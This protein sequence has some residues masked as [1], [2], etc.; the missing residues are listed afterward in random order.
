MHR[1]VCRGFLIATLVL[2]VSQTVALAQIVTPS[3]QGPELPWTWSLQSYKTLRTIGVGDDALT[4]EIADTSDLQ[5]RG[6]SY[7]DGLE[8]GTGMLFVYPDSRSHTFWMKGMRFCLDIIWIDRGEITGAAENVCPEPGVADVALARYPSTG[9]AQF[10]LEVPAGWLDDHGYGAGT[11]VDLSTV[12][13][14]SGL[15]GR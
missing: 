10:V 1:R 7:R 3:P 13:T 15:S 6:L 2:V 9:P 11:P 8:P 5:T 14:P 4:V 12:E